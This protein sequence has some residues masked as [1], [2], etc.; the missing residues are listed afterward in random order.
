MSKGLFRPKS[1]LYARNLQHLFTFLIR[2]TR[3]PELFLVKIT[4]LPNCNLVASKLR[5]FWF[6]DYYM[7]NSLRFQ[8]WNLA[9]HLTLCLFR[10]NIRYFKIILSSPSIW[11]HKI[12]IKIIPI[13][14]FFFLNLLFLV[15][16]RKILWFKY[17]LLTSSTINC[18][19]YS[20]YTSSGNFVSNS[21]VFMKF[22]SES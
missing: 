19:F 9:L 10:L 1:F 20:S 5:L 17:L 14:C 22:S 21:L 8:R 18:C 11:D 3:F 2:K 6:L 15:I 16:L 4:Y 7:V 13:I 12:I